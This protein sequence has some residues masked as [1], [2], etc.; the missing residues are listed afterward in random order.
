MS[1]WVGLINAGPV[2]EFTDGGTYTLGGSDEPDLNVTY[3]YSGHITAAF[4]GLNFR[5]ALNGKRAADVT[6]L[7]EAAVRRLG[8]ARSSDYW[9]ATEGNAGHALSVLLGWAK[10]YPEAEFYVN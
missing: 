5:E 10:Q 8:T 4:D 9:E 3:N 2:K 1:W 6:P 7:L